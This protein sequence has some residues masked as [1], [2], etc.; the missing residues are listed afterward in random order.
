MGRKRK[1]T[2]EEERRIAVRQFKAGKSY[3]DISELLCRPITTVKSIIYRFTKTQK[4]RNVPRKGRPPILTEKE[5]R[6]VVRKVKKDAKVSAPKLQVQVANELGKTVSENTVRNVLYAAGFHGRTA[7]RKPYINKVNRKKRRTYAETN[8]NKDFDFWK[9]V[10]FTDESKFNIFKSDGR[11]TVWRKKNSEMEERN[12][13][14]TVKHG[15]GCIQVWGCMSANGVGDL[16]PIDGI[17]DHRGYI[18]ILKDHLVR[19]VENMGLT[20]D[21]IFTHDNDP[22]HTAHN[23]KLWLLYN[24]PHYMQTPPQSPDLNPIEH[25]WDVLERNIR[26]RHISNK[27]DLQAALLDEWKNITRTTT[28]TLVKSMPRRLAEVIKRKGG[29]TKY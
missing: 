16:H 8:R 1:E 15:G 20:G 26:Q 29:P 9:R 11:V 4:Y 3:K 5:K 18:Q 7:R 6:L 14:A 10:V 13:T 24:T 12:L 28:E 17:L 19:S 21:Y 25:L 23:T 27:N 2:T 22:K